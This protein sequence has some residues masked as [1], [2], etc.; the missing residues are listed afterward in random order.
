M[1]ILYVTGASYPFLL[2]GE[3]AYVA[4]SLTK[5]LETLGEDV[6]VIMPKFSAIG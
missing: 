3:N 1:K 5:E 4:Y 6:R 2:A